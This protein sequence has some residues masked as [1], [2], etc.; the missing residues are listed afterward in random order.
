[1][2]LVSRVGLPTATALAVGLSSSGYFIFSNLGMATYGI[3][4]AIETVKVEPGKALSL[5][6]FLYETAAPRFVT[7]AL[8]SVVGFWTA[9]YLY[10]GPS[11]NVRPYLYGAGALCVANIPYTLATMMANIK[12]LRGMRDRYVST[13]AISAEDADDSWKRIQR[14]KKQ[15]LVRVGL[16][17]ASYVVGISAVFQLA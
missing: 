6:A 5:W 3:L 10:T 7:S 1:M 11:T 15:H 2:S 4:P 8:G 17:L 13:G 12:V 9:A 16:G 14:W